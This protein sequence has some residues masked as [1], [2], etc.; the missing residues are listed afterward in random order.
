[1]SKKKISIE[2][3]NNILVTAVNDPKTNPAKLDIIFSTYD[4]AEAPLEKI[5]KELVTSK[6]DLKTGTI[7]A[8]EKTLEMPEMVA[9]ITSYHG[10]GDEIG[11]EA[12]LQT[13]LQDKT[14]LAKSLLDHGISPTAQSIATG[15]ESQF[16]AAIYH[17]RT[18]IADHLLAK[19]AD[20]AKS[21]SINSTTPYNN[22]VIY[23]FATKNTSQVE[24]F[25]KKHQDASIDFNEIN[26]EGK[27]IADVVL[28]KVRYN[29][30]ESQD[31]VKNLLKNYGA[32]TAAEVIK[33][34]D[35]AAKVSSGKPTSKDMNTVRGPQ[36][37]VASLG[38]R[39]S[40]TETPINKEASKVQKSGM[41]T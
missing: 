13:I 2:Q 39:Y 36:S 3:F 26:N 6:S 34:R 23:A 41:G 7:K 30:E 16:H 8:S 31:K 37:T 29:T 40:P 22:Y 15:F 11:G 14:D 24:Y 28:E 27:T 21:A 1:M 33:Q 32:L 38:E 18:E 25:S 9:K 5:N 4:V 20:I 19:G 35:S 10:Y 12:L 17:S